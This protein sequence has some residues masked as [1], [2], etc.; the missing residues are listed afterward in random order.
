MPLSASSRAT[1]RLGVLALMAAAASSVWELL[2]VQ[3][4]GTPLYIA[5]LPGPIATLRDLSLV[6]G[7]LL[8]AAGLLMPHATRARE[9]TTLVALMYVG[10]VLGLSAQLYAALHG[11][12]GTQLF[13]LR[14]DALPLFVVKHGGVCLLIGALIELGRRVLV[15]PKGPTGQSKPPPTGPREDPPT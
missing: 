14:P 2:A 8:I 1:L 4:P 9:P 10:T 5:T 7:L 6:I 13:D 3:S 11:M 12:H 15:L